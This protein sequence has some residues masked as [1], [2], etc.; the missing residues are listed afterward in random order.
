[1]P[2]PE[3]LVAGAGA[4]DADPFRYLRAALAF[5]MGGATLVA[6][7]LALTG[8]EPRALMLA[9][10]LWALYGF[11]SGVINGV[12]EPMV[13]LAVRALTN[14]GLTRGS[15]FSAEEALVAQGF[16]SAAADLYHDRAREG[17]AR[18]PATLR[19]AELLAGPLRE[20]GLAAAELERLRA[21]TTRLSPAD[22][23]L[24]GLALVDLYDYRLGNPGRAMAELR[25]LID[26]HPRSHHLGRL[27]TALAALRR[28]HFGDQL[29]S[30]PSATP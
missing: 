29:P 18:T 27:R 10:A 28:R 14:V 7:V 9:G 6:L 13:D 23:F 1:M 21:D 12:L 2:E 16:H 24:I 30:P 3:E 4:D 22:D 26:R 20:P 15:G 19:R 8:I 25:R 11:V 17:E 5:L